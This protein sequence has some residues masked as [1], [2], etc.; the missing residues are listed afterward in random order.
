MNTVEL[1]HNDDETLDPTD[2]GLSRR[3]SVIYDG[4]EAGTWE[5]HRGGKWMAIL[6]R[7]G[8]ALTAADEASLRQ[9]LGDALFAQQ[10]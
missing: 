4:D 6:C 2:P 10:S 9:L 8:A 3:G 1:L 5:A 7:S